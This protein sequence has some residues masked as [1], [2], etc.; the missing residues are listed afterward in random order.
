[1]LQFHNFRP[2]HIKN[3]PNNLIDLKFG[4]YYEAGIDT[5]GNLYIWDKQALDSNFD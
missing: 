3:L 5:E 2:H 1:L 4:Q